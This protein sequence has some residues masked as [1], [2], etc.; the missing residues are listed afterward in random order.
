VK[1]IYAFMHQGFRQQ[2]AYKVEGWLGLFSSLIWF[3]LFAGI[4]TSLLRGDQE[5]LRVQMRYVIASRFLSELHLIPT[6]ELSFKFKQGDVGLEL[7][8]PLA[9]PLRLLA[10]FVGRSFFR[11]MRAIP[12]FLLI[13][14]AYGLAVPKLESVA[15]FLVSAA[16]GWVITATL[17]LCLSLIAL[18]TVQFNEAEGLFHVAVSLF[19]GVLI[20][21]Y[22]LPGWIGEIASYLPFAGI[23]FVPSA[24]LAGTLTGPA[25]I[26]ALALQ[27]LWAL[28]GAA[29]LSAMWQAGSRKLVMQG[30]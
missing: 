4:W 28:F 30:G 6:W 20:P 9:L 22:Y 19:S 23:Y 12:V 17:Q 2:A 26:K 21:L 18:W 27:A 3:L 1:S 13:W 29:A 5:A 24:I 10:D 11:L 7:I 25:L 16:L 8:R 14:I 15:L